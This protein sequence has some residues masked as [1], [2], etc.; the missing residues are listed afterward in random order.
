MS[1]AA[2]SLSWPQRVVG[3]LL[4]AFGAKAPPT[5]GQRLTVLPYDIYLTKGAGSTRLFPAGELDVLRFFQR[6]HASEEHEV[7]YLTCVPEGGDP[8]AY[9]AYGVL[10]LTPE[11]VVPFHDLNAL[12]RK[13]QLSYGAFAHLPR[14]RPLLHVQYGEN[15][16]DEDPPPG[17][18]R[19]VPPTGEPSTPGKLTVAEILKIIRTEFEGPEIVSWLEAA[20]R[21][22]PPRDEVEHRYYLDPSGLVYLVR[23][24]RR[25]GKTLYRAETSEAALRPIRLRT[26]GADPRGSGAG[27]ADPPSA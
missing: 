1:D 2:E 18:N 15:L 13:L 24:C 8:E 23:H 26:R 14:S 20:Y 9:L 10:K 27:P 3:L 22:P 21:Q 5:P 7:E 19:I 4:D 11:E 6:H 17:L 16:N 25:E 12:E